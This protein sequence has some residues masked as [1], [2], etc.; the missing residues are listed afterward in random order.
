METEGPG[1]ENSTV[2]ENIS[3]FMETAMETSST[4][5]QS[6]VY[7]VLG[8]LGCL[9]NGYVLIVFLSSRTLRNK[10]INI[11]LINQSV[12][13]FL[14]CIV[15]M[16]TYRD[17]VRMGHSIFYLYPTPYGRC[18]GYCTLEQFIIDC[19]AGR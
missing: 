1:F 9:G 8:G 4:S 12:A 6:T 10:K 5:T 11:F 18:S 17:K 16:I 13:D 7:L 19:E 3:S 14:C 15:L 2:F